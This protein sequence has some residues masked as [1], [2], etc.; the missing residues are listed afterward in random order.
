[1]V[2]PRPGTKLNGPGAVITV[3]T[4]VPDGGAAGW[5]WACISVRAV[6]PGAPI[7]YTVPRTAGIGAAAARRGG[8]AVQV[9]V[10]VQGLRCR[11]R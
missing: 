9:G 3:S 7:R 4:V 11:T 10:G 6:P 8:Q 5:N 2:W 1:M